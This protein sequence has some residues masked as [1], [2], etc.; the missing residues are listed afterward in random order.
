MIDPRHCSH[1][2]NWTLYLFS[3]LQCIAPQVYHLFYYWLWSGSLDHR[4]TF[5]FISSCRLDLSELLQQLNIKSDINLGYLQKLISEKIIFLSEEIISNCKLLSPIQSQFE[6][7][8]AGLRIIKS[9]PTLPVRRDLCGEDCGSSTVPQWS[10]EHTLVWRI[11]V[12]TTF[13]FFTFLFCSTIN[14]HKL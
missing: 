8:W 14:I 1:E 3:P 2:I 11:L 9:S 12:T 10:G 6:T 4:L 5:V 7:H 13:I